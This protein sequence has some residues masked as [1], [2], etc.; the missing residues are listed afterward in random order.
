MV[1]RALGRGQPQRD[2]GGGQV[3]RADPHRPAP[4]HFADCCPAA[5]WLPDAPIQ[6]SSPSVDS[7]HS[8]HLGCGTGTWTG[9]APL[10]FQGFMPCR[11]ASIRSPGMVSETKMHV[12]RTRE[13]S[14]RGSALSPLLISFLLS[15]KETEAAEAA[16]SL[17]GRRKED[18]PEFPSVRRTRVWSHERGP[19]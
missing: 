10:G 3:R 14:L 2:S 1:H 9:E 4:W 6:P 12:C 7:A 16:T 18:C 8:P 11:A 5:A 15:L 17:A 19:H 13:L